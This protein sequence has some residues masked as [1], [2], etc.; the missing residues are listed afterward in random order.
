MWGEMALIPDRRAASASEP[1]VS[2]EYP[3]Y[4]R[5]G[6]VSGGR[7]PLA[8]FL[9]QSYRHSAGFAEVNLLR[10]LQQATLIASYS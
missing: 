4:D 6:T 3:W 1:P 7:L 10:R 8:I 5:F 9:F 2:K